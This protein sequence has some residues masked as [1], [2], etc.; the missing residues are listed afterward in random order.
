MD[1]VIYIVYSVDRKQS[2]QLQQLW[3]ST[4][5]WLRYR[6]RMTLDRLW[7]SVL[8]LTDV[9]LIV[10]FMVINTGVREKLSSLPETPFHASNELLFVSIALKLTEILVDCDPT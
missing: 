3:M 1:I 10:L 9:I 5:T 7:A 2:I 8:A 6:P 4:V